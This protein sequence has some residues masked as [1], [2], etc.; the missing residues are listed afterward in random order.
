MWSAFVGNTWLLAMSGTTGAALLTSKDE[1]ERH[2]IRT[3][4]G[5]SRTPVSITFSL[6]KGGNYGSSL[7]YQSY[8]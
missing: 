4:Q 7:L 2:D 3:I 1:M 6:I 5:M 8:P